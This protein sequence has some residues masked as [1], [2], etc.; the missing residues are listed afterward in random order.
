MEV[1]AEMR[2][3]L[4]PFRVVALQHICMRIVI[5][6]SAL[7]IAVP[8]FA[9]EKTDILVM[10]NG[11]RLTGEIK[12]LDS[13]TLSVN[14]DYINGTASLDWSKVDHFESKQLFFV[15]T[16]DGSVYRGTPHMIR[17]PGERPIQIEISESPDHTLAVDQAKVIRMTETSASFW[18]RFNGQINS[19]I[20]YSKGNQATQYNIAASLEYPRER[21]VAAAN[22]NS[23]LASST[24]AAVSTRNTLDLYAGRLLR[25]DNW[26]Y[27]GI[28]DFLQSS[29]QKIDLQTNLGGGVGRYLKNTNRAN[30]WVLGGLAWQNTRYSQSL[31]GQ[32][33]QNVAAALIAGQAKFFVF[34]KTNLTMNGYV[35]PAVSEPGR[36]YVNTSVTYYVKLFGGLNW[37]VSL[38][39]NWDNQPPQSVSGSDYG[40]RSGLGWSFG[41]RFEPGS[42]IE[43]YSVASRAGLP[44]AIESCVSDKAVRLSKSGISSVRS[45][46]GVSCFSILDWTSIRAHPLPERSSSKVRS[47]LCRCG[48][49][50]NGTRE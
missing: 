48:M 35:F 36:V 31:G 38:Y 42:D 34:N 43:Y 9:R 44:P 29:T 10:N 3:G 22:Y 5:L 27:A 40:A 17:S 37:N 45:W 13:G 6:S 49:N 2:T 15:K 7:A 30:I 20:S 32:G 11:D 28:T 39:G 18:Q 26:F 1:A 23:T 8:L 16:Q 19:G 47:V 24:G 14:F 46:G 25:W 12:G 21:W 33:N 50:K 4:R 41:N